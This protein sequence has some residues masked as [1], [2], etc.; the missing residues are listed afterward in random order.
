MIYLNV[1]QDNNRQLMISFINALSRSSLSGGSHS[2]AWLSDSREDGANEE[3]VWVGVRSHL[4]PRHEDILGLV[5]VGRDSRLRQQ[6][7]LT[8]PENI[9]LN[10]TPRTPSI[11]LT[12]RKSAWTYSRAGFQGGSGQSSKPGVQ[13]HRCQSDWSRCFQHSPGRKTEANIINYSH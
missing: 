13:L 10:Q 9:S 5:Q 12:V 1:L 4:Q 7:S 2:Q 11:R 3:E 6:G 8:Q